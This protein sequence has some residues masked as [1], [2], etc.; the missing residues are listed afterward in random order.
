MDGMAAFVRS[1]LSHNRRRGDPPRSALSAAPHAD[2]K[3]VTCIRGAMWDVIADVR[4]DSPAFG[5]WESVELTE[6]NRVCVFLPEGVAHGFE[7]LADDTTVLYHL[8][9]YYVRDAAARHPMG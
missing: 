9:A 7:T 4:P 5:T 6:D 1:A 3:L 8:G 2:A